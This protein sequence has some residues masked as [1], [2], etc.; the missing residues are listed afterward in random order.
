MVFILDEGSLFDAPVDQIWKYLSSQNHQHPSIKSLNRE[1]SGNSVIL[2]SERNIL[3]EIAIVKVKNT[4]Y[5]P[6][7]IVQEYLEGPMQGSRAFLYYTPK[8]SKTGVTVVGDYVMSGID[9]KNIRDVVLT[10]AQ[11]FFDEDNANLKKM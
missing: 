10:Q 9:E 3:G 8:V 7:G 5:P 2:T 1:M 11:R 6:F 4:L